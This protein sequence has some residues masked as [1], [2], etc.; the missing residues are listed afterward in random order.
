MAFFSIAPELPSM[1]WRLGNWNMSYGR[2]SAVEWSESIFS[3]A[4]LVAPVA[5]TL[6]PLHDLL[7][8]SREAV[9]VTLLP[10]HPLSDSEILMSGR[11][12]VVDMRVTPKN[13]GEAR[14]RL[15]PDELMVRRAVPS[16]ER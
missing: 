14:A 9:I 12:S 10:P 6:V 13:T 7:L 11:G 15:W 5:L 2:Y 8:L 4:S 16:Q 1:G 3:T